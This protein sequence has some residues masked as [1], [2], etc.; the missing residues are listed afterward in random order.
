RGA[1]GLLVA[2]LSPRAPDRRDLHARSLERR[3]LRARCRPRRVADRGRFLRREPGRRRA[4][5]S[6][7]V[8][9]HQARADVGRAHVRGRVLSLRRSADGAAHAPEA[10]S[11]ALVR[12]RGPGRDEAEWT[13]LGKARSALPFRGVMR[14]VVLAD[15]EAQAFRT[16]ERAYREWLGHMR[17]LWDKRGID[18]P[19][20]L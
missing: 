3:P 15:T 18:F 16:A 8:A 13:A 10:S 20:P 11:T 12:G 1:A 17:Y 6:R 5:V 9:R 4:P 19:L 7:S 2:A 14:L